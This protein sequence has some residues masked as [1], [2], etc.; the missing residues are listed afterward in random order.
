MNSFGN[1]FLGSGLSSVFYRMFPSLSW[2]LSLKK[3]VRKT[4]LT[5]ISSSASHFYLSYIA[6]VWFFIIGGNECSDGK[7]C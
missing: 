3:F 5:L 4:L 1:I 6:S 7:L 2:G